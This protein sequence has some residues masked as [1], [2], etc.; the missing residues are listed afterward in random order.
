M[1]YLEESTFAGEYIERLARIRAGELTRPQVLSFWVFGDT[2]KL[3][4]NETYIF[5]KKINFANGTAA[6]LSSPQEI[7]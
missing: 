2:E 6:I 7:I 1:R 4:L 3:L 5:L